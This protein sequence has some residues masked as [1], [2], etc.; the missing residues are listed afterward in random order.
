[1][2]YITDETLNIPPLRVSELNSSSTYYDHMAAAPSDEVLHSMWLWWAII[3]GAVTVLTMV[4]FVGILRSRRTRR[5]AF[6]LYLVFL[7]IP[8]LIFS[9]FCAINC[10]L[11][12][13]VGHYISAGWC[14]FQSIYCVFGIGANAWLN[15]FIVHE[16]FKM[17]RLSKRCIRYH[18]PKIRTVVKHVVGVYTWAAFVAFM[19]LFHIPFLKSGVHIGA[20]CLPLVFDRKSNIFFFVV[21]LPLFA[22]IPLLYAFVVVVIIVRQKLMVGAPERTR[23]LSVYFCRLLIVYLVMWLPS[24]VFLFIAGGWIANPWVSGKIYFCLRIALLIASSFGSIFLTFA[25][26]N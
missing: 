25:F 19:T 15:A 16:L 14:Q 20:A 26:L 9:F 24:L 11:N 23:S 3:A 10:I 8:D 7:M 13:V 2:G 4:V 5:K 17:L 22:L 18:P 12:M 6:N 1:M 21:F